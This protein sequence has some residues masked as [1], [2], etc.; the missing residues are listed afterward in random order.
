MEAG[1]IVGQYNTA[2]GENAASCL[3]CPNTKED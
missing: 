1:T 2:E 3:L